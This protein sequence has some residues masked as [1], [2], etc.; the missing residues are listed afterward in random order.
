[1]QRMKI[2]PSRRQFLKSLG[3]GTATLGV[4]ASSSWTY[5]S[6]RNILPFRN[7]AKP[8][9][10]HFNEN[11][12][13]MSPK[14]LKAAQEAI[15]NVGN[16]Y[17]DDIYEDFK[18][19][20]AS[21]HGVKSEQLMFGNG[22]TE[23]LQA[24]ATYASDLKSTVIEP[25]PTFGALRRYCN[26]ESLK[27]VRVPVGNGFEIDIAAMKKHA[28]GQSGSVLI[29]LC[30]PNNPTGTIVEA[31]Q[32]YDWI[33]TAPAQHLFLIDEAYF[34]Y[35]QANQAYKSALPLIKQGKNNVII[36][37]TFSKA[38]GM[39]GMRIG[40]GIAT[41]ELANK[42]NPYAAGFNLNAAGIAAASASLDD[43]LFYQSSIE[44]NRNAKAILIETLD[45]LALPYIPSDTNF[46][47]HRIGQP[48]NVYAQHMSENGIR[49]GRKM[50]DDE[51][52][53]RLSIGTP[54]EMHQFSQTLLAFRERGW[55]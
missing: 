8:L 46:L 13:G 21:Y 33:N 40:Y 49:V 31:K 6:E 35:A 44:S 50:T 23:V 52:W 42:I 18:Q 26:A 15:L 16:R 39:A 5:A 41:S 9:L 48:I 19:Q 20:L 47:L 34:D 10:L 27:V 29:N 24:I 51:Y 22:S 14:A 43:L 36:T 3:Y 2:D 25:T 28:D 17:P 4:L 37:R 1:M 12:L 7:D 55:V 53:N 38:Y 45:K 32:L 54:E 30:N 11:S